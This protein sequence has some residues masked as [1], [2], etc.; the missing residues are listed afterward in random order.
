MSVSHILKQKGRD[1]ITAK[2]ADTVKHIAEL[3]G[4]KRIAS[5]Y[6]GSA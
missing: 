2:P 3:L 5:R 4:S 6:G 1:V